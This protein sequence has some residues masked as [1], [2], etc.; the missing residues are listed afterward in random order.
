MDSLGQQIQ[1]RRK[2]LGLT[3]AD[4]SE[5]SGVSLHTINN[6]ESENG[7]PTLNVILKVLEVL[8]LEIRLTLKNIRGGPE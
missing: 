2:S 4:L 3:Q 6:L 8:G 7:N 5:I 1:T